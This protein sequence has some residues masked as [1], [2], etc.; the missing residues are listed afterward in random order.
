[1]PKKTAQKKGT[2][3]TKTVPEKKPKKSFLNIKKNKFLIIG[4]VVLIIL[5]IGIVIATKMMD[6]KQT[7]PEIKEDTNVT[8]TPPIEETLTE[9]QLQ[10]KAQDLQVKIPNRILKVVAWKA[11]RLIPYP[12]F[13]ARLTDVNRSGGES[14]SLH[15]L[16]LTGL[17]MFIL[18]TELL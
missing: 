5:I 10:E 13:P 18:Q 15:R 16:F 9:E 1:M 7:V 17:T 2:I 8:I 4:I 3:K 11:C 14:P 12:G 6:K